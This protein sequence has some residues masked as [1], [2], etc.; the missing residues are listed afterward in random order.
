MRCF[1]QHKLNFAR[2]VMRRLVAVLAALTLLAMTT[3]ARGAVVSFSASTF[4]STSLI[5]TSGTL[6][7]AV[8]IQGSAVT[9]NTVPF[10]A[11]STLGA[12][13]DNTG[14]AD[15]TCCAIAAGGSVSPTL[16]S[17]GE[18]TTGSSTPSVRGVTTFTG[19]TIGRDYLFQLMSLR[20]EGGTT[21]DD[22]LAL[23]DSFPTAPPA[24][25][26]R[27]GWDIDHI[28]YSNALGAI[29]TG[30]FTADATSQTI[31]S[32]TFEDATDTVENGVFAQ[33]FQLRDVTAAGVP[34]PSTFV[35]GILGLL[36]LG[37]IA[38]R[39]RRR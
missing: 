4:S 9:V 29:V 7:T 1:S 31:Y 32:A 11:N 36:S 39:R 27:A 12:F 2:P 33:A 6:I 14:L 15:L 21:A 24:P 22:E 35:L 28:D 23:A 20:N 19:L 10:A 38:W 18:R 37:C 5:D 3:N 16:L 30:T 8:N 34:E 13:F 17:E 26:S 25:G